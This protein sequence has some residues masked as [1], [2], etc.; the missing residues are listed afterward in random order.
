MPC[1]AGAQDY[2][3]KPIRLVVPTV[4]GGGTDITARQI[5]P[6]ISEHL[7]QQIVIENRPGATTTIGG[8]H[9]ARSEPD[10][11]TLLM[12]VSSITIIP[13]IL[14]GLRYDPMTDFAPVSQVVLSPNIIVAH[15]SLPVKTVKDLIAFARPRPGQ[16]NFAAGGAG[17]SQHL[18]IELFQSMAGVKMVHVPYKGQG[19]AL[20]DTMAGH[21]SLMMA[22]VISALPHVRNG[23]LRAMGVTGSKRVSIAQNIPTVSE[24]GLPGYAVLQWYGVLVPAKT[25]RGIID[26]IHAA[27]VRVVQDPAITKRFTDNGGEP[28][29]NTPEQFAAVIQA[30]YKKWGKVV[31]DAGIKVVTQR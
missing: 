30:D 9:V 6:R 2:P 21:V 26:R 22:N 1:V 17:S 10:G 5:A 20:I 27:V 28:V 8:E 25:P 12:G 14:R 4:P 7:G 11:Y 23:R 18:A 24:A 19:Q 31:K 3:T 16:L 29:G 15:P 13:H